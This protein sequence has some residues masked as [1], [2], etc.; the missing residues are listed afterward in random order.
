MGRF[1]DIQNLTSAKLS[2]L[3]GIDGI[4]WE[5][6]KDKRK[7]GKVYVNPQIVSGRSNL[8]TFDGDQENPGFMQVNVYV[9]F[10]SGTKKLTAVI[11]DI[12]DLFHNETLSAT[13]TVKLYIRAISRGPSFR[14][15]SWYVGVVDVYYTCYD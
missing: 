12:Y 14:E 2:E 15:D 7:E 13:G 6:V 3:T 10:E 11:D 1:T 4:L 9:P 8:I 5:N